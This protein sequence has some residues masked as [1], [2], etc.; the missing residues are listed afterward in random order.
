MNLS[1]LE[2]GAEGRGH[3][4]YNCGSEILIQKM[5]DANLIE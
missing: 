5:A 2:N 4:K 3:Q 1:A